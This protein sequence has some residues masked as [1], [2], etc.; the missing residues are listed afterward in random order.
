M[1]KIIYINV[2]IEKSIFA[3]IFIIKSDI[4]YIKDN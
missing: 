2:K 1:K 3:I 4:S